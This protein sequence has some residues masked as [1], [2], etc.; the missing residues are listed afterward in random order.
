[1]NGIT[2]LNTIIKANGE[3]V[4]HHNID[5]I[6]GI[7]LGLS[8]I[9]G[10][11]MTENDFQKGAEFGKINTEN[12]IHNIIRF[13][14]LVTSKEAESIVENLCIKYCHDKWNRK[15][16]TDANKA[17]AWLEETLPS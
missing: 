9:D 5:K 14:Y 15:I 2:S 4:G 16:F 12:F 11:N 1:M 17:M 3:L 8:D 7:L 6:Q 13:A 10:F